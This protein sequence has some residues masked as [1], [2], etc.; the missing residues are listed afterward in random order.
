MAKQ[1][2]GIDKNQFIGAILNNKSLGVKDREKVLEL[3]TRDIESE[4]KAGI[5][6]IVKEEINSANGSNKTGSTPEQNKWE[7]DPRKVNTFLMLFSGQSILKYAAHAWDPG[8]FESYEAFASSIRTCLK[9]S[10]FS[11][12][13]RNNVALSYALRDYLITDKKD[14]FEFH[15]DKEARIKIGLMYPS[16]YASKW[17]KKNP[18]QQLWAMPLSEFPE[19]YQPEGLF[20][21]KQLAN[22]GDVCE[23][24]KHVIEFREERNDFYRFIRNFF[25]GKNSKK[26]N[27]ESKSDFITEYNKEELKS[28]KFYTYTTAVW[29]AFNRVAENIRSRATEPSKKNV[30]ISINNDSNDSF[31]LHILHLGSFPDTPVDDA[32]L[33]KGSFA[34]MRCHNARGGSLLSICDYS[35]VGRFKDENGQLATHRI[36]FLYPGVKPDKD[37][38]PDIKKE[39]LD[40][41]VNGFEYIFK[42]Y[43]NV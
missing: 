33:K 23:V 41:E 16:G 14:L 28:I 40:K 25:G 12:L 39:K 6:D 3:L 18:G 2:E 20:D 26:S 31:E 13:Y 29:S 15:W 32:K 38:N 7:H 5:R 10:D 9:Q 4:I 8:E 37:G 11:N 1:T 21:N 24:F 34:G 27:G 35:I 30:K 22:M 17:M 19:E 42:F 36:D 43:K